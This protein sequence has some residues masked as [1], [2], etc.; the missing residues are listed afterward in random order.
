[1]SDELHCEVVNLAELDRLIAEQDKK[2]DAAF[3]HD[4]ESALLTIKIAYPYHIELGRIKSKADLLGWALHL[5]HKTWMTPEYLGEFIRR[6]SKI[7][8]WKCDDL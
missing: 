8:R 7:K 4:A 2:M 6:V 5:C 3:E 1:M